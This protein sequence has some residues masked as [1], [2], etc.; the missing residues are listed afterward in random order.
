MSDQDEMS[1]RR[2]IDLLRQEE[3]EDRIVAECVATL[4]RYRVIDEII[5]RHE[6]E[7]DPL[8]RCQSC[9]SLAHFEC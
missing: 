2:K 3:E 6:G 7:Y 1:D 9:G 5:R 8:N 4:E